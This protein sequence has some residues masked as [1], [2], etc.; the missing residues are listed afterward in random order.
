[1]VVKWVVLRVQSFVLQL[2][3]ILSELDDPP[4]QLKTGVNS[5]S[6]SLQLRAISGMPSERML[7]IE[8]E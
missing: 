7:L 8:A 4:F 1:M 3:S 6:F 5:I 2:H